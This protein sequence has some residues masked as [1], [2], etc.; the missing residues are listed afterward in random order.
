MVDMGSQLGSASTCE[1]KCELPT[2]GYADGIG[3]RS[4][5]S[6]QCRQFVLIFKSVFPTQM[7]F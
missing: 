6:D 5:H 2:H 7:I 3:F 1:F 4:R